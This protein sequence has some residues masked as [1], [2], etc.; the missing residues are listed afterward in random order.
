MKKEMNTKTYN[1]TKYIAT[2]GAVLLFTA[3][4]LSFLSE[5]KDIFKDNRGTLAGVT[6]A[7]EIIGVVLIVFYMFLRWSYFKKTTF[8]HTKKDRPYLMASFG[9]YTLGIILS[10]IYVILVIAIKGHRTGMMITFAPMYVIEFVSLVAASIFE[11]MSRLQEQVYLA[12]L[13]NEHVEK[14]AKASKTE[15][16]KY[17]TSGVKRTD[18]AA[19][20]LAKDESKP[21]KKNIDVDEEL[22]QQLQDALN[23]SDKDEIK[24]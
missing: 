10:F 18:A 19:E 14:Q 17:S 9:L 6:L 4:L 12:E 16:K 11:S 3:P 5:W 2:I 24:D 15:K 13:E 22:Q 8:T 23:E 21:K 7:L 20:M 1:L